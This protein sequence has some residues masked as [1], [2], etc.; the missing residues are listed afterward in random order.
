MPVTLMLPVSLYA[1]WPQ[2]RFHPSWHLLHQ[3]DFVAPVTITYW[4]L[5]ISFLEANELHQCC[6]Y[7]TRSDPASSLELSGSTKT[8]R[9]TS[10]KEFAASMH[11]FGVA[12]SLLGSS[13]R[14]VIFCFQQISTI[15]PFLGMP[16]FAR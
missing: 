9:I 16:M 11:C 1:L 7:C 14:I 10:K 2:S 13:C 4:Y 6:T 12:I 15:W 8:K 5:L 3:D